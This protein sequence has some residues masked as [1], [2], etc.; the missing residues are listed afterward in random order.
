MNEI[1]SWVQNNWLQIGQIYL[2]IVGLASVIVAITPTKKDDTILANI[3]SFV[4]K[5][6]ALN[7]SK[8]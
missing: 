8:K 7:P 2:Q 3:I 5:W 4:G 6:F 1:I